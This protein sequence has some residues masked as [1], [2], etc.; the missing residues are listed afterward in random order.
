MQ[1][2]IAERIDS[3]GAVTGA[4]TVQVMSVKCRLAGTQIAIGNINAMTD[5][6]EIALR[7]SANP[8]DY[9][10][11][12]VYGDDD[13]LLESLFYHRGYVVHEKLGVPCGAAPGSMPS[14]ESGDS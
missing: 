11:A 1:R 8:R 6:G 9:Q 3:S 10:R 12:R 2:I 13:R 4:R 7:V 5:R 14:G